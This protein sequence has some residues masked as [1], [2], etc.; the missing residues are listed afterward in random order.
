MFSVGQRVTLSISAI[1][2]GGDGIARSDEGLVVFV[3]FTAVG[4]LISAEITEQRRNFYRAELRELL[5]PGAGRA[6][7][8]CPHVGVCGGCV[9]Q[10][11]DYETEFAAKRQQ[12]TDT[13]SRLGR[14][15]DF[16]APQPA[17][18][19]PQAYGYRNK[20]RLEA[21]RKL[22]NRGNVFVNYGYCQRDNRSYVIVKNCPLAPDCLN[23]LIPKAIHSDWG[24]QNAKR[25]KPY[26]LTLRV[27]SE[28]DSHYYY[29]RAPMN[30]PW[31]RERL[32]EEEFSVPLGS[33][34]QINPPVAEELLRTV[35]DWVKDSSA[36]CLIDAYGGVGT[37][38]IALGKQF[39]YRVLIESDEQAIAAAT[40]NHQLRQLA[41]RFQSG[42]TEGELPAVLAH[43]DRRKSL[44]IL[45][46]PRTGCHRKVVETLRKY[47]VAEIVYVSCNPAT[48]ARDLQLLCQDELYTPLKSAMFDMF[49]R[50]AHFESAVLLRHNQL[51]KNPKA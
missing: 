12:F 21:I 34:W 13:I 43:L 22:S 39:Q 41:C 18:P 2:F 35:A 48:L 51:A 17:F 1:A 30:I 49:P 3:P 7:P 50:T 38:S 40:R 25:P 9:Y 31:L 42:S 33:F 45:D 23:E 24:R 15:Q 16:P 28:G 46:P 19:A 8:L 27:T 5:E 4:D 47:P 20:I 6:E 14:F 32:A 10:H 36:R 44:L 29:G 37:F 11:L 26:P